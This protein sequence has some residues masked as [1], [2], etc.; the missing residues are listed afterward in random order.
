MVLG[1]IAQV[2][3]TGT[4]R[5]GFNHQ[6]F[7]VVVE[8]SET[9]I[10]FGPT[11]SEQRINKLFDLISV[12]LEYGRRDL[13]VCHLTHRKDDG[14]LRQPICVSPLC[15]AIV[16]SGFAEQFSHRVLVSSH[17]SSPLWS[18]L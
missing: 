10:T 2:F 7:V 18:A 8:R 12:G 15:C 6:R 16:S 1:N 14:A 9:D 4:D 11:V 5:H 17:T 13:T 3:E